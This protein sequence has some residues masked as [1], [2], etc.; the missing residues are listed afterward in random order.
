MT[1]IGKQ[2]WPGGWAM[3]LLPGPGK[4]EP[5]DSQA[6]LKIIKMKLPDKSKLAIIR[7]L[8]E[9][10]EL[11]PARSTPGTTT[12][13]AIPSVAPGVTVPIRSELPKTVDHGNQLL[14]TGTLI[15]CSACGKAPYTTVSPLYQHM[16]SE[17][18]CAAFTPPLQP[19][20]Q[21]WG[22]PYGNVAIDCPLCQLSKTV[23][24]LGKGNYEGTT[25]NAGHTI[26][27]AGSPANIKPREG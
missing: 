2:S 9:S 4:K 23:W 27:S 20:T 12:T 6:I 17:E 24:I 7:T 11:V 14:P 19:E 22:D 15:M 1:G 13:E 25:D 5:M 16:T 26:Q 21:L 18:L 8:C 10:A 3:S